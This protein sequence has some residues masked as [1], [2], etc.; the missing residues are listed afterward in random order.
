MMKSHRSEKYE[1]IHRFSIRKDS[2]HGICI[3]VRLPI[4]PVSPNTKGAR[5]CNPAERR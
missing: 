1:A 5:P 3:A 2:E 4:P